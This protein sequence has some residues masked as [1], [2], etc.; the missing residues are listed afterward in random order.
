MLSLL[1]SLP[2]P[3][4]KRP[5]VTDSMSIHIDASPL[6]TFNSCLPSPQTIAATAA[7]TTLTTNTFNTAV[8]CQPLQMRF[9]IRTATLKLP[10]QV[11]ATSPDELSTVAKFGTA[12]LGG[13]LGWWVVHP[14]NTL[15][16]RLNLLGSSLPPGSKLPSFFQYSKSV[17]SKN[18]ILSVYD[19]IGAGTIRQVFYATSR[20]GLFEVIRD[21][22]AGTKIIP[23]TT[24]EQGTS[25]TTEEEV[26]GTVTPLMR[27]TAGLLS[28]GMAAV[29]A[30]PAE[31]TLVRMSNDQALPMEQRRNYKHFLDCATRTFTEEGLLAFWKGVVP[32]AQRA[33]V[34][35]V[36]QVGTFD[37]GKEFYE[38]TLNIQ[39][40]TTFN[41]FCAAMTSGLFYA[42]VTMPLESAKNRLAT[43]GS[44]KGGSTLS[45][46]KHVVGKECVL[47]LW[48]GF[49]PYYLRCGGHTTSMFVIV[50]WLRKS[51]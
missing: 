39:R 7:T 10:P 24:I 46:I 49:F 36:C 3:P 11:L 31:V 20:F 40:G 42:L 34:V 2:K 25:R 21:Q 22:M 1:P 5:R 8:S 6:L 37:Q 43:S 44:S 17:V 27:L 35:G 16:V 15:A 28:G 32:F 30:C 26:K 45:V 38:K 9:F 50:E 29:I 23:T 48:N 14:F 19:G 13:V 18:G 4:R 47:A 41:V 33:V 12:G 51:L